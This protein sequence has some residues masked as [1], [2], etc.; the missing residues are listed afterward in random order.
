MAHCLLLW[1]IDESKCFDFMRWNHIGLGAQDISGIQRPK[2][3]FFCKP[4]VKFLA[5]TTILAK[6][7]SQTSA[8]K[9]YTTG[10]LKTSTIALF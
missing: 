5:S 6:K 2:T 3:W 1:L 8:F 10:P 7:I 4:E 9:K